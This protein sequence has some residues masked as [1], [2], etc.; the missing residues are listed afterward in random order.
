MSDN[1]TAA[2]MLEAC[3]GVAQFR[4]LEEARFLARKLARHCPNFEF[5][6]I[7]LEELMYNAVEHGNLAITYD[8]K[9]NLGLTGRF[10]DEVE[11]RLSLPEY[12]HRVAT[13]QWKREKKRIAFTLEDQGEGFDSSPYLTVVDERLRDCHGRGIIM[14]RELCFDHLQYL[15]RGNRVYATISFENP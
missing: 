2:D 8:E 14:A 6:L 1:H 10:L 9:T 3:E 4:T 12:R 11:R 15:G 5:A 7:G 13:I